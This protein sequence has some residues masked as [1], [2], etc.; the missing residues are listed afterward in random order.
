M[1]LVNWLSLALPILTGCATSI[2]GQIDGQ[3]SAP[4]RI[5][6]DVNLVVLHATV[7]DRK[8]GLVSG[9]GEPDFKVY[10]NGILQS[11]RLFR[12]EDLPVTVGL[13]VDHSGSMRPK[14]MH[15]G[16]ATRT[17]VR[18]S[19][20]DDQ[21][22]VVNFNEKV[23]LGLPRAI[24]FTDRPEELAFAILN[25]PATGRTALYDAVAQALDRLQDGSRDRKVLIVI[26]DGG[27]NASTYKLAEVLSA[28]AKSSAAIYTIGIFDE[29]DPD[30]NPD[31]LRRLARETGGE[32]FFPGQLDDVIAICE[33][34]AR[35]IRN[36]YTIGYAPNGMGRPGAYRTV[37]VEAGM[38]GH[39]RLS[40]RAR[41]SYI[42]GGPAP[43]RD[44][45]AK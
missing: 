4:Y 9:L 11:I 25:A 32:A 43:V 38:A 31:V 45:R 5:A 16:A 21:I 28:A 27:D 22:F 24:Q 41:T 2:D 6:V 33:S 18:S 15:V 37:R 29:D 39:G 30:R 8:G 19:N 35:D 14:L 17:F 1:R 36:Q 34:I 42:A 3:E 7:R 40:V 20:P 23:T 12:H 10:E 13:V 44:E 26:S